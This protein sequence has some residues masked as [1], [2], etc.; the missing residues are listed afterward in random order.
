M[1]SQKSQQSQFRQT[2]TNT[3]NPTNQPT[4]NKTSMKMVEIKD[5]ADIIQTGKTPPT[6]IKEYFNGE[7][8]WYTPSD[9][10]CNKILTDANRK[11]SHKAIEDNRANLLPENSLFINC[12]G[13]IGKVGISLCKAASNQQITALYPN[14]S[15]DVDYL[16][17][18]ILQNKAILEHKAN[19]AVVPILNNRNLKQIKIPL[20]PLPVQKHIAAILDKA[21][22]LRQK[23]QQLI[24]YYEQL[25]QSLFLDMF[26][27]PVTNPMG[28]KTISVKESC[29][30][31]LGG[32]TPSKKNKDFYIGEIPWV[33]PK[34]MKFE[35]IN[36]SID[37]IN[38]DAIEKSSAKLI[39]KF[40]VLMVIRS[41]ILKRKL[42]LAINMKE[43]AVNQDM[44]A[45]IPNSSLTNSYFFLNYFKSVAPYLLTKV[46]GVTADNLE[47]KVIKELDFILPPIALQNEFAERVQAI[48]QQKQQAEQAAHYTEE[49]FQSLL[50]RAFKGELVH[51][52]Q[53]T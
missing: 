26:G 48:E 42:P 30:S 25:S 41:G 23:D 19:N 51:E 3:K 9:F 50:Q 33:T 22:E 46:R 12:I 27:D 35:Y 40:S 21:D 11:I 10:G 13:D 5:I 49:L 16:Y 15:A 20:P 37:K 8:N 36:N 1:G 52:D 14:K 53:F 45:F 43:V 34:D 2:P 4:K 7:V 39:P 31:I 24:A 29:S 28:W 18:W 47:F 44:K 17:Y 32:G 6:K 38:L